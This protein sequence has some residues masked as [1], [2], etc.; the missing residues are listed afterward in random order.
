MT[1]LSACALLLLDRIRTDERFPDIAWARSGLEEATAPPH[2]VS[3]LPL[4]FGARG[5]PAPVTRLRWLH[6]GPDGA[7]FEWIR[8]RVDPVFHVPNRHVCRFRVTG[9][10]L[11]PPFSEE[12]A[13]V[14][15]RLPAGIVETLEN[16]LL[17][18]S[19]L[20][21]LQC[22]EADR[23]LTVEHIT[24]GMIGPLWSAAS[25]PAQIVQIFQNNPGSALLHLPLDS[26]LREAGPSIADDPLAP[27]YG[28]GTDL[29]PSVIRLRER[30]PYRVLRHRRAFLRGTRGTLEALKELLPGLALIPVDTGEP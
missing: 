23:S 29:E 20:G 16:A 9:L 25:A 1:S 14:V 12:A 8:D 22:L 4:Y 15:N 30:L 5:C 11:P 10:S 13:E 6:D 2:P 18:D 27:L 28:A 24:R 3:G 21:F 7:R 17:Q 19:E 26:T